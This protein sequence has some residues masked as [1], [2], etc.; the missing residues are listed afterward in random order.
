MILYPT[1]LT[2]KSMYQLLVR[3]NPQMYDNW[4]VLQMR[5]SNARPAMYVGVF[6]TSLM[7]C[8][9]VEY[10]V[11]ACL[12]YKF[13]AT[14]VYNRNDDDTRTLTERQKVQKKNARNDSDN[15][16]AAGIIA[17]VRTICA[18][19]VHAAWKI[20]STQTNRHSKITTDVYSAFLT[21][22]LFVMFTREIWTIMCP[23]NACAA[24]M[25]RS[26]SIAGS[27]FFLMSIFV[28]TKFLAS[29]GGS[30]V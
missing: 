21:Q 9:H 1:S 27:M 10:H 22:A 4:N 3:D 14:R 26:N 16:Y 2:S 17:V 24:L 15:N 20:N 30:G 29:T 18:S 7:F 6:I 5:G 25:Y 11:K 12:V 8:N 19:M 28:S 13:Y 23:F